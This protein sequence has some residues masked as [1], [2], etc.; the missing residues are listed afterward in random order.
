MKL[1]YYLSRQLLETLGL[2]VIYCGIVVTGHHELSGV[3]QQ[4]SGVF[5]HDIFWSEI[6]AGLSRMVLG[7]HLRSFV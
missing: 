2:L 4:L 6:W 3:K 5:A 7:S 1:S